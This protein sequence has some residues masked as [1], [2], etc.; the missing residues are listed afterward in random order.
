M[1]DRSFL[2]SLIVVATPAPRDAEAR[3]GD[4]VRAIRSRYSFFEVLLIGT[5][6][7]D[8]TRELMRRLGRDV[9]HIRLLQVAGSPDFDRL[10][11]HGYQECIGDLIVLTSADEIGLLDIEAVFERLRSGVELVRLRRRRG[12]VLGKASSSAVRLVTGLQVDT[13]FHRTLGLN[14]T[15]LSEILAYPEGMHLFRFTAHRLFTAQTVL[16]TDL[17]RT[18]GGVRVA[19]RRIDLVAR[20]VATAAPRLLRI[21]SAVCLAL[22]GAALLSLLYVVGVWLFRQE[23]AEGWTTMISLLALWM[24]VQSIGTAALCLGLSRLLDRQ[25]RVRLSRL[26]D[27]TSAGDLFADP[28]LLNVESA[29]DASS[30]AAMPPIGTR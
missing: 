28:S 13:R 12:S 7:D 8:A 23:V 16:E 6:D 15:I 19:L 27:D 20:L 18:R 25:E 17:P 26:V 30:P 11:M 1:I 21:A 5:E 10:A 29:H 2:V 22:S 24:F 3:L 9:P 4:L 14:R